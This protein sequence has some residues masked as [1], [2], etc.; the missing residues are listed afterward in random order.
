MTTVPETEG[1]WGV[2]SFL[3]FA[4]PLN[5]DGSL[6]APDTSVYE[7]LEVDGTRNF[8]L[9]PAEGSLVVNIGNGRLRDTI[10][11]APREASRAELTVGYTQ[12]KLKSE[13]MGG[14]TYAVG[15]GRFNG[16]LTNLQGSEPDVAFMVIQRGH[17]DG[18][19]TRYRAYYVP[20]S[21]IIPRDS[22]LN[23]NASEETFQIVLSNTKKQIWGT[24]FVVGTHG[25]TDATYEEA[26]YETTPKIVAWLAD[27]IEDTFLLPTDKPAVSTGKIAVF[28]FSTGIEY[29]SGVTKSVTELVFSYPPPAGTLLVAVY[30]YLP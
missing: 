17:N 18:G 12:P 24:S 3:A 22:P 15:E 14:N 21:R 30:E 28:R 16:R 4:Y 19:L 10:Y 9:T 2:D 27:G 5:S 23:D 8:N 26:I 7:G 1:F 6:Q 20:K 29:T 25:F 11:R 13:M